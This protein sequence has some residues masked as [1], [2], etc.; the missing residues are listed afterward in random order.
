VIDALL[1]IAA[2]AVAAVSAAPL[3]IIIHLAHHYSPIRDAVLREMGGEK[4][5]R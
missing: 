3:A 1:I 4:A 2:L 5:Q